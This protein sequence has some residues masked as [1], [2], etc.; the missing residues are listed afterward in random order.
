MLCNLYND[1]LTIIFVRY[2]SCIVFATITMVTH[3]VIL[4]TVVCFFTTYYSRYSIVMYIT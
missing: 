2:L 3:I 1:I 4:L